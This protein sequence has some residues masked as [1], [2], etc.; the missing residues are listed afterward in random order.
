MPHQAADSCARASSG[1]I[2][3]INDHHNYQ[4]VVVLERP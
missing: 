1:G 2:E 4:T 3:F